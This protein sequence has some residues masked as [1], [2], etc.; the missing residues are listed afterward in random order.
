MKNGWIP[1]EAITSSSDHSF[2]TLAMRGR[3]DATSDANN[4]AGGWCPKFADE[5]QWL[6]VWL[7]SDHI[8]QKGATQG[9]HNHNQWVTS[10]TLSYWQDGMTFVDYKGKDN[11]VSSLMKSQ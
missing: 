4:E 6:Q 2:K 8:I 10:Y 3:L 9:R 1:D 11:K 7:G 5:H